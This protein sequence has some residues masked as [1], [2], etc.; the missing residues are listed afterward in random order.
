MI[1]IGGRTTLPAHDPDETPAPPRPLLIYDGECEFCRYSIARWRRVTGDRVDYAPYQEI[2]ARFPEIPTERF[3]ESVHLIE[4]D[5][6]WSW[7]AEAVFRA[8][9]SVPGRGGS[10][11]LYRHVPGFATAS[12]W[13]YRV[14]ARHRPALTWI[15]RWLGGGS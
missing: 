5:G 14:V 1:T 4:P 9:A 13:C 6:R 10:L 15:T 8:L 7:G 3:A 11:W 12:E 2:A